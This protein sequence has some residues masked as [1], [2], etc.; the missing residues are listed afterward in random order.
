MKL[1]QEEMQN[2][3]FRLHKGEI[4]KVNILFAPHHGRESGQVPADF[5]A[6][7]NPDI[8]VVGNAPAENL[9]SSYKYY[10]NERT[11]TQNSARDILFDCHDNQIDVYTS[12][13]CDN[14]PKA[15]K[16]FP[17]ITCMYYRGSI[18]I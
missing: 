6:E 5:L 13:D 10:G 4:G 16:K 18:N 15:L 14:L 9:E 8:V 11:I 2:E 3:F 17:N 12:R 7:L 1:N